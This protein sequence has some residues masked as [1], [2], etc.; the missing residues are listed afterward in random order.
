MFIFLYL[1]PYKVAP[2]FPLYSESLKFEN[3][4]SALLILRHQCY[5]VMKH[6]IDPDLGGECMI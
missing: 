1:L 5:H 2:R 3:T 4:G 6:L